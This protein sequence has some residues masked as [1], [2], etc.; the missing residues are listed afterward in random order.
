MFADLVVGTLVDHDCFGEETMMNDMLPD[1]SVVTKSFVM[2]MALSREDFYAACPNLLLNNE[3]QSAAKA[4][5][6]EKATKHLASVAGRLASR[7]KD[8]AAKSAAA[9]PGLGWNALFASQRDCSKAEKSDAPAQSKPS[10]GL[11]RRGRHSQPSSSS[12]APSAA[13][14]AADA[15]ADAGGGSLGTLEA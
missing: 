2:V 14:A 6:W 5:K 12:A 11:W 15:D 9:K 7:H 4:R 3:L 13:P 8:P 10:A 1:H